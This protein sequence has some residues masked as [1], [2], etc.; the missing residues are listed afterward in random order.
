M[1]DYSTW[2]LVSAGG[3][4][5]KLINQSGRVGEE[6]ASW[7]MVVV[8][9][10]I[11]LAAFVL[12]VFPAPV[13]SPTGIVYP[14][15][16]YP[17][18]LPALRAVGVDVKG[19][20]PGRPIDPFSIDSTAPSGTYE[21]YLEL[22]ISFATC[23]E[24]DNT[25]D[26]NDPFTFLDVSATGSGEFLTAEVGGDAIQ[27]EDSGGTTS[28][29]T[30]QDTPLEQRVTSPEVEWSVKWSQISSAWFHT[31]LLPRL[32]N[33]MDKV[34]SADMYILRNAPPETILF[35]G[36]SMS[37]QHTWRNGYAGASPVQLD[38]KFLEKNFEGITAEAEEDSSASSASSSS[39]ASSTVQVTHNHIWRPNFGWMKPLIE[40]NYMYEEAD[41]NTI[42][43]P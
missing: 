4:R 8:I 32:R 42:F 19:F 22:T 40:G 5:H 31:T 37:Q 29:M 7:T 35:Q 21:E 14:R 13:F 18:G 1:Q 27:W 34:N 16:F 6:D 20:T 24:N 25:P 30:E 15:R 9:R 12:E 38:L 39:A 10:A 17:A 11:D 23:P 3:I 26:P 43:E 28:G 2:R 33:M 36:W 41:L